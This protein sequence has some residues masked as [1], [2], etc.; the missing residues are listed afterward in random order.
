MEQLESKD[1]GRRRSRCG[2]KTRYTRKGV[3]LQCNSKRP[4]LGKTEKKKRKAARTGA[5]DRTVAIFKLMCHFLTAFFTATRPWEGWTEFARG[6]TITGR[7]LCHKLN[8]GCCD[9]RGV[10]NFRSYVFNLG[11]LANPVYKRVERRGWTVVLEWEDACDRKANRPDDVLL[12]GYFYDTHAASPFL[13]EVAGARRADGKATFT[14][15]DRE[16]DAAETVHIYPYFARED[17]SD[18]SRSIY[19]RTGDGMD[20]AL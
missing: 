11:W 10:I 5:Q 8:G 20:A 1:A 9:E 19:L 13:L 4:A 7:D 18:Y 16:L 2:G 6:L 15:P 14:I 17:K 12:V 3:E